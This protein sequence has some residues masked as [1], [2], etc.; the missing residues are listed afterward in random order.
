MWRTTKTSG[1]PR[2]PTTTIDGRLLGPRRRRCGASECEDTAARHRGHRQ[3]VLF[4]CDGS[5]VPRLCCPA[6][7]SGRASTPRTSR[8]VSC[9]GR[10]A[11]PPLA[12]PRL[13]RLRGG[14]SAGAWLCARSP[15]AYTAPHVRTVGESAIRYQKTRK[16]FDF[17]DKSPHHMWE[18]SG[19]HRR[20]P[21]RGRRLRRAEP[22][23]RRS[24]RQ[25]RRQHRAARSAALQ[26]LRRGLGDTRAGRRVNGLPACH[27]ARDFSPSPRLITA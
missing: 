2:P 10:G 22:R 7:P 6:D 9:H 13:M 27:D 15:A 12:L 25:H 1:S 26:L 19:F 20:A 11:Q 23:C 3:T 14:R 18:A 24:D 21:C 4:S 17:F 8:V 16:T 5:R